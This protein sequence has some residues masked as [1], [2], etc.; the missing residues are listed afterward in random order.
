MEAGRDCRSG[1]VGGGVESKSTADSSALTIS[2]CYL[3]DGFVR[4][5]SPDLYEKL[6]KFPGSETFQMVRGPEQNSK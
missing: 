5:S 4:F 6:V 1:G 3:S 2:G